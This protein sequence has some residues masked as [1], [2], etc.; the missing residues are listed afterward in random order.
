MDVQAKGPVSTCIPPL[1]CGV[2][3]HLSRFVEDFSVVEFLETREKKKKEFAAGM[4]SRGLN[5]L[6]AAGD[7]FRREGRRRN[8]LVLLGMVFSLLLMFT[9]RGITTKIFFFCAT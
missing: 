7:T 8:P 9:I 4:A 2:R 5:K 6:E 3:I 1:E